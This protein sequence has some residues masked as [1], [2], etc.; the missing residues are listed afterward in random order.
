MKKSFDLF[1]NFDGQCRE[2]VA[3]YAKAFRSEVVDIMSYGETPPDSGYP[4]PEADKDKIMYAC[5]PIFGCNVMFMDM[6]SE[7][8]LIKGNNIQ[9]TIS[10]ADKDEVTRVFTALSEG[11][12]V[13]APL[14]KTFFSD[15]YGMVTDKF[16]IIWQILFYD[17]A[18]E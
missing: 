7:M 11:G 13:D 18:N 4:I 6:P 1:L 2:A 9:P 3:F 15:L 8:P 17:E 14:E 16:G 10:V 5:V 12:T